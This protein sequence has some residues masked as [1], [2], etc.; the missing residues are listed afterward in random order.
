M[1]ELCLKQRLADWPRSQELPK[2]KP[3]YA[4][5]NAFKA[6]HTITPVPVIGDWGNVLYEL[7]MAGKAKEAAKKYG[8]GSL[9]KQIMTVLKAEPQFAFA[10]AGHRWIIPWSGY[11]WLRLQHPQQNAPS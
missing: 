5:F 4:F 2:A 8:S 6:G 10:F 3:L 9:V 1:P 11:A 7:A